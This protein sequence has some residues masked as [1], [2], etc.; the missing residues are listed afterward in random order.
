VTR[1]VSRARLG[2]KLVEVLLVVVFLVILI[3][4]S[5]CGVQNVR[6]GGGART[7]SQCNLK[8]IGIALNNFAAANNNKLP[9]VAPANAPFF[10]CGQTG[11]TAT[12]PG[13]PNQAPRFQ[14]GLLSWMEG[15]PKG[16]AAPLDMNAGNA[17]PVGSPCS[18]S[19][20]AYWTLI[21]ASGT[22]KLP[23]SFPRGCSLCIGAAEMTTQDVSYFHILPFAPEPFTPAVANTPST[24]A[25][26]FSTGGIQVVLI[27]GS[28]RNVSSAANDSGDFVLSH[29]PDDM[30]D[31]SP[32]W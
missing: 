7:Q 6:T 3:G 21:R 26:S 9:N 10:F 30:T 22:L 19:I 1:R 18:Y 29:Q 11:G 27:D 13:R 8:Q 15:N 23:E 20:P 12:R 25:T 2:F 24:T 32:N 5:F 14:D 4:L 16:L 28:V 31:F 17:N